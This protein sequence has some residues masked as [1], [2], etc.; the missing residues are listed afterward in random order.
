HS[1]G[2]R[3]SIFPLIVRDRV[4]ALLYAWG[5]TQAPAIELL[6]QATSA[7][8]AA[9][10]PVTV[11]VQAPAPELVQIAGPPRRSRPA[12][13][14][15]PPGEQQLHLQAQRFARVQASE[16]RL[17]EAQAVQAGRARRDLYAALRE[18]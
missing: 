9:L 13:E 7:D 14:D 15:L 17:R 2:A 5:V 3:V 1:A 6:C 16:M 12:W 8:W 4:P 10:E 18:P 11:T